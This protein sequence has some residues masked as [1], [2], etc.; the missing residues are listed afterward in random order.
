LKVEKT[1]GHKQLLKVGKTEGHKQI[2]KV[3]KTEGH[4]KRQKDTNKFCIIFLSFL[5]GFGIFCFRVMKNRIR[6][7]SL[8]LVR[9]QTLFGDTFRLHIEVDSKLLADI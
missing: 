5:F 2:L 6:N 3:G 8:L 9:T 7:L 4:K 1:E